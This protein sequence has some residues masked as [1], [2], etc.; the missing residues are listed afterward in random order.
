MESSLKLIPMVRELSISMV[1]IRDHKI[2]NNF[3]RNAG[4]FYNRL[5]YLRDTGS[6]MCQNN[7][8][9]HPPA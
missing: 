1:S 8:A 5:C 9:T 7:C 6:S 3:F 2:E 4:I